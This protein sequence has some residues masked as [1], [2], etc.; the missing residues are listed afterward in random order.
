[1]GHIPPALGGGGVVC[2]AVDLRDEV[3]AE[4]DIDR[5]SGEDDLLAQRYAP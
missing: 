4:H 5:M 3:G 2:E 1:M